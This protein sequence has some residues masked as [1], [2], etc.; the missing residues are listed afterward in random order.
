MSR[1]CG[2]RWHLPG[3]LLV[4]A[5]GGAQASDIE[6]SGS[7]RFREQV[8]RA[9]TLLERDAPSAHSLVIKYVGRI[10]QGERSGMWAY[11]NPPTYEM[12]DRTTFYSVTWCAGT[13]AH[14]S[15]HSALYHQY[16]DKR[17]GRVPDEVWTGVDAERKCLAHQL[18]VLNKINAPKNEITYFQK[19]HGTHHDINK[20][21]KYDWDDYK[22]RNW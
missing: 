15:C 7:T 19:L 4:L 5:M 18:D 17:P 1:K 10:Q 21:G 3:V 6:I 13:I 14:D 8:T 2:I 11:K 16:K 9:L 22:G 20:D 12:A